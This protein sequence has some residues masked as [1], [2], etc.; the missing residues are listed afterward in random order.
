MW[1]AEMQQKQIPDEWSFIRRLGGPSDPRAIARMREHWDTY[2]TEADLDRLRSFGVTHV[3]IP[4]GW[5]LVDY[6]PEDGFVDGGE[7]Y[8]RRLL[9]WLQPRG[10]RALLDLHALPGAQAVDQS[11]TGRRSNA[12]K[13]FLASNFQRGKRAMRRLARLVRALEEE[14]AIRGVVMGLELVNEPDWSFWDTS[15]GIREL[16]ETMVP[17]LRQELPAG[18]YTLF[19]G[20][21]EKPQRFVGAAWL[22]EQRSLHP[23]A[24]RG[25][26]YDAHMYH[27][28]GDDNRGGMAWAPEVDSCKTCCRDPRLLEPLVD[29]RLP[30]IVGEY[31]LNTGYHEGDAKFLAG[32]MAD[33]L[34]L[35]ASTAGV[36][37]SFFWNHRI[38]LA[39]N[40]FYHE[41]SLLDL[42]APKGPLPAHIS[43]LLP[44]PGAAAVGSSSDGGDSLDPASSHSRASLLCPERDLRTCPA[45]DKATVAWD[46]PCRWSTLP[47]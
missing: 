11:S 43:H 32:Y 27:S 40:D 30:V 10:M 24:F 34:S 17:E 8:L 42:L 9:R 18:R 35:W 47:Q 15:P 38:L 19:L 21:Q 45:F 39:P 14:P 16:Y 26:V 28:Y 2:V 44:S 6:D 36:I 1:A 29:A 12:A 7:T 31:S 25:V 13:F 41:F 20:F 4:L 5:W 23:E 37:G 46:D 3:R 22:A 33:Q